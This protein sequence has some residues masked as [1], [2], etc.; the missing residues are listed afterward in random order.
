M[1][2][3]FAVR[4]AAPFA[5]HHAFESLKHHSREHKDGWGLALFD[6]GGEP[7]IERDIAAA[8]ASARFDALSKSLHAKN[9]IVHLRLA[10]V[11]EVVERNS[12]PFRH[13]Q[14]AFAHNGTVKRFA[15]APGLVEERIDPQL[16][17]L[18]RGE[19]DS[20]RCFYLFLTHLGS[21]T[22]AHDVSKALCRTMLEVGHLYDGP[23]AE[24]PA[25]N[26]LVSN[27]AVTAVTR[28]GRSLWHAQKD[29]LHVI[30]SDQVDKS[31]H[32]SEVAEETGLVI[33]EGLNIQRF[34]V[35]ADA[36]PV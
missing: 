29:G 30:A 5:V 34:R 19:T 10:S 11:G 9:L 25:L 13:D 3:L 28:R 32:W 14:W 16:R 22:T 20:E 18:I 6:G 35:T 24:K 12:H 27:G 1:C 15:Y 8:H 36:Q 4:A 17:P 2:R 21:G 31:L 7:H 26:F 33:D 23:D